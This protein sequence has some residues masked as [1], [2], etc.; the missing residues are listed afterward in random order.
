MVELLRGL[1]HYLQQ[2]VGSVSTK[3]CR[4]R[5]GSALCGVTLASFTVTGT[6]TGVTSQQAFTDTAR[7][8][9]DDYFA[10]GVLTWTGGSNAGLSYRVRAYASDTFTLA[11]PPVLPVQVGDTYSVRAG[12]RKRLDEDCITKFDNALN[13]QGEPHRPTV[14][15]ITETPEPDAQ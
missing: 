7:A 10:E 4:T 3:T 6:L 14:D 1:Q 12:C 13:F 2:P 8:E 9:A 15:D 5:L 11:V